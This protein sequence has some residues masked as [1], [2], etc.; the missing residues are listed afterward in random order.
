MEN[1]VEITPGLHRLTAQEEHYVQMRVR[2]LNPNAAAKASGY[3]NVMKS[4]AELHQRP[5]IDEAIVFYREASKQAAIRA[6]AIAEFTKDDATRLYL[7][8]HAKSANSTEEIKAVDSLVKLHGLAEPEKRTIEIT[9]RE[10]METMDDAAL[11][12]ITGQEIL[13]SPSEYTKETP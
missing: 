11:L 12:E 1:T 3:T 7:E 8:A 13:L 5:E 9:S 2:G 10:Q 6:G 4:V